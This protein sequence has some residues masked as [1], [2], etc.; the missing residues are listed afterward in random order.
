MI[1]TIIFAVAL[2]LVLAACGEQTPGYPARQAPAGVLTDAAQIAA[3]RTLFHDK[4]ATCHGHPDEGRSP[5][6]DFFQPPASDF[7][8]PAYRTADPA[9]LFWRI[10]VGKTVEPYLS[11]GS[12]MPSWRGLSDEE[13]WQLVAYLRARAG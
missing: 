2:T 10:E 11:R 4:C 1:R 5:R 12:V 7:S 3:G 9:Y 13:I 8:S 6:A